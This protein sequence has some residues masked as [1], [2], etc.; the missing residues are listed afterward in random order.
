MSSDRLLISDEVAV[1]GVAQPA[2][3]R[4]SGLRRGLGLAEFAL[5]ELPTRAFGADLA[6]RD[7]VQRSIELTVP[8][9][10]KPMPALL[11]TG[12]L[13]RRGAAVAGVVVPRREAPDRAAVTMI[14]AA[15]TGPMPWT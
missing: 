1:D 8:G 15:S 13:D 6:D 5:V 10:G 11:P 14:F 7:Q 2:F 4:P 9:P 3:E 12:G